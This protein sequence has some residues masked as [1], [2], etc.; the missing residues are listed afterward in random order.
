M[1]ERLQRLEFFTLYELYL[2]KNEEFRQ[3]VHA[4]RDGAEL[5]GIR[6]SLQDIYKQMAEKRGVV[7]APIKHPL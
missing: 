6:A 5:D 1:N 4:R 3:A 2:R 7:A